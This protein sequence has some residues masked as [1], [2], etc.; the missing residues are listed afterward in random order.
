MGVF[1]YFYGLP[2][3]SRVVC[4]DIGYD[5]CSVEV[6]ALFCLWGV[7]RYCWFLVLQS[8]TWHI[9]LAIWA[10]DLVNSRFLSQA[11]C[12]WLT[13]SRMP[14]CKWFL[15]CVNSEG[16]RGTIRITKHS[17]N[18][19]YED[20][21]RLSK[22]WLS[23]FSPSQTNYHWTTFMQQSLSCLSSPRWGEKKWKIKYL[24]SPAVR[25]VQLLKHFFPYLF[26]G[27]CGHWRTFFISSFY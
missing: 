26:L 24:Q 23:L 1:Y 18:F 12:P 15:Y 5:L 27:P 8:G 4:L 21:Y 6:S 17:C 11:V 13:W 14:F 3:D 7:F 20:G 16:I 19:N 10:E 2:G 9:H 22:A 25:N